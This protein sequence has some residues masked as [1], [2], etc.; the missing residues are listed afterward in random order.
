MR[1]AID[2]TRRSFAPIATS[3]S[4]AG[5][6]LTKPRR[7]KQNADGGTRL[8]VARHDD[9]NGSGQASFGIV[10]IYSKA[11]TARRG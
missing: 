10:R 8:D 11:E 7:S 9:T 1:F 6:I 2:V 5:S 3:V 4:F